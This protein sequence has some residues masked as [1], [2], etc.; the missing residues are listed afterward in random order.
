MITALFVVIVNALWVVADD[1]RKKEHDDGMRE[2][3]ELMAQIG[4]YK[5]LEAEQ[6]EKLRMKSKTYQ[7]DLV[8]QLR[9]ERKLKDKEIDE[10][11]REIKSI[12]VN[13]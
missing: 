6:L 3:Q 10:A 12:Q 4:Q 1:A 9:Y 11:R 5:R 8:Q 2:R 7:D 13:N